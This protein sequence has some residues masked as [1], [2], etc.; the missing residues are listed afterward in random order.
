VRISDGV[1]WFG[2]VVFGGRIE[3]CLSRVPM[4]CLV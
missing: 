3:R 1:V 2:V 4:F